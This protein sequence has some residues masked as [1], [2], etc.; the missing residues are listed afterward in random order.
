MRPR[1]LTLVDVLLATTPSRHRSLRP[2]PWGWLAAGILLAS[3]A[4]VIGFLPA[5]LALLA[6]AGGAR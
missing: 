4:L 5:L 1:R 2:Q 6:R 3:A